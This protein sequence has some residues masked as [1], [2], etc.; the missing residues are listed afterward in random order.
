MIPDYICRLIETA[1]E[2]GHVCLLGTSGPDGP[3][4]SP[5]GSL[6]VFDT[7]RLAY[8]ER[9]FST[10]LENLRRNPRVVVVYSNAHARDEGVLDHPGGILRF[11][12]E[13]EVHEEGPL[14]D[15][16]FGRL[17]KREA[18]HEGADKGIGVMINLVRAEDVRGQAL[19]G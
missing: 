4:V 8:W 3:N 15:Q 2:D 14:R 9:S 11:Y 17:S 6:F 16:I 7:N 18:E 19:A 5:K 10:A 12:G 1:R 13:A